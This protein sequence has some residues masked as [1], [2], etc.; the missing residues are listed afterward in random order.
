MIEFGEDFAWE[1]T[2]P[3]ELNHRT[4]DVDPWIASSAFQKAI[5]RGDCRSAQCAALALL[6][7]RSAAFW[8]RVIVVA[9]EDVGAGSTPTVVH[10]ALIAA[11]KK[12]RQTIAD[13]R[14]I[15]A[16]LV[17]L[18]A[19]SPKNR[20][21]EQLLTAANFHPDFEPERSLSA[22]IL[23]AE[24]LALSESKNSKFL[25]GLAVSRIA[26]R[27]GF[28]LAAEVLIPYARAGVPDDVIMAAEA[29]FK[30]TNDPIVL[31]LPLV[32]L[33]GHKNGTTVAQHGPALPSMSPKK[34]PIAR[35]I[36]RPFMRMVRHWR[37]GTPGRAL[38]KSSDWQSKLT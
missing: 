21:A 36:W 1:L 22:V 17:R 23:Q 31:V 34:I 11:N 5:R 3:I 32:W 6:S 13:E 12:Q 38:R 30:R 25:C 2:Q 16:N 9:F 26:R 27:H 7:Q 33:L 14:T 15:A 19:N 29:A 8:R 28:G 20:A 24:L 37:P 35:R 18:L 10:K 4:L